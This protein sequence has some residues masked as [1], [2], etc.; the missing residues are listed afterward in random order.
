MFEE[1]LNENIVYHI[2][3]IHDLDMILE[4]GI[5]YDDKITYYVKYK[6]FHDFFDN[7]KPSEIPD[8][9]IRKKA[10]F[11]SLDLSKH[12]SWHSHS[13]ILSL[14]INP[15]KCWIANENL[16]NECY[17]PIMLMDVKGFEIKKEYIIEKC[18]NKAKLYWE[19]SCSYEYNLR[20]RNDLKVGY[21]CEI[22][23]FHSI[24]PKDIIPLAIVSDHRIMSI[25]QWKNIAYT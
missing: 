25:K 6:K 14:K 24:K 8:W 22:M 21:D 23:I 10:V 13:V 18:I 16:A 2:A 17:E 19:T 20:V 1:K 11:G 15:H 7:Y 4:K 5:A 9:V 12:T 3:P